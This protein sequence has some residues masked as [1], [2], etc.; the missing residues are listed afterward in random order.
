MLRV[1]HVAGRVG[2]DE[3]ALGR[4]EVAVGD[5]DR[6]AL[7]ALG[8][9]PVRDQGEVDVVDRPVAARGPGLRRGPAHRRELVLVQ[10]VGVVEQA[11]DQGALAVVDA[12][13]G[14]EAQE[15]LHLVL[16]EVGLDVAA[17]ELAIRAH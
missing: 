4:R 6:D 3:L 14:D 9:E 5:V 10:P 7:L 15:L 17:D 16:L 2:D 11:P 1:L 12:A 8:L 13:D